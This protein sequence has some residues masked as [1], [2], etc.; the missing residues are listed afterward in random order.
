M[1]EFDGYGPQKIIQVYNPKVGLRGFVV[2]DNTAL[3]PGKGGCRLTAT[4]SVDEVSKLARAM[5]WK[6]ALAG[7]PFGGAKSGIISDSDFPTKERKAELIKAFAE[8]L[9]C[10]VPGEYVSAP[11]M[12]VGE[13]EMRIFSETVGTKKACTGKPSDMGGLPHELGSTGFGVFHSTKVAAKHMGLNLKGATVAIEGFGNVGSFAGKFLSEAGAKLVGISD[14]KGMVVCKEGLEYEGLMAAIKETGSVT[15]YKG[16]CE[17]LDRHNIIGLDVDILVTA[18]VPD[19]IKQHE[20]EKVKAKLIVEGSNIPMTQEIEET[21]A[22]KGILIVPD[23][24]ANAGGVISSYVEYI[25]GSEKD[26][27]KMVEEKITE[28]TKN[29]LERAGS[30]KYTR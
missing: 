14:I 22:D 28:N 13:E 2:I 3:G 27:F 19:L 15:G 24:V 4:V 10:V 11:D 25:G 8:G 9:K 20:V 1:V 7:L 18:A 30:K 23:F 6:C 16:K 21:L 17:K 26:M 12:N 5:T 29:M